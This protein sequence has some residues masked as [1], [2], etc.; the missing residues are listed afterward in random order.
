MPNARP[1]PGVGWGAR[2]AWSASPTKATAACSSGSASCAPSA[3]SAY[4]WASRGRRSAKTSARLTRSSATGR[5]ATVATAPSCPGTGLDGAGEQ[6]QVGAPA[7]VDVVQRVARRGHG[8]ALEPRPDL[9]PHLALVGT[10]G[11][12]RGRAAV[13]RLALGAPQLGIG[14]MRRG[15]EVLAVPAAVPAALLDTAHGHVH[16]PA[17]G[18]E[19]GGVEAAVLL[20]AEHLLALVDE[21]SEVGG[22]LEMEVADAG[23]PV[24]L[25]H[26][27]AVVDGAG[28]RAVGEVAGAVR[29]RGRRRAVLRPAVRRV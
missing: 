15:V 4:P 1:M 25:L 29:A 6:V 23:A 7:F 2:G 5:P 10:R 20:R 13:D 19:E 9:A 17:R 28:E 22:V 26:E 21:Q 24:E 16:A 3:S 11:G 12:A 8:V 18:H 14:R 27:R